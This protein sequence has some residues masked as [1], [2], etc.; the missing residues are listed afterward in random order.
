MLY[1]FISSLISIETLC[2]ISEDIVL[3]A[4]ITYNVKNITWRPALL[5]DEYDVTNKR[6]FYVLCL[7]N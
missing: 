7:Q 3:A 4:N 1:S 5:H 2:F 6:Q